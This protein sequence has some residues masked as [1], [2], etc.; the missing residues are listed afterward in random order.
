MWETR[1]VI[2]Y[3]NLGQRLY[4]LVNFLEW[5]IFFWVSFFLFMKLKKKEKGNKKWSQM[6]IFTIWTLIFWDFCWWD[7][8]YAALGGILRFKS[9]FLK[10]TNGSPLRNDRIFRTRDPFTAQP[11]IATVFDSVVLSRGQTS[12]IILLLIVLF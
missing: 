11:E 4:P 8:P 5:S 3:F 10:V 7:Y 2:Q 12:F 9:T 1:S 6:F